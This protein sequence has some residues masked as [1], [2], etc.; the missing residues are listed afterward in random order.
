M[1]MFC[2]KRE[3][4]SLRFLLTP[5]AFEAYMQ[6]RMNGDGPFIM[7]ILKK[8]EDYLLLNHSFLFSEITFADITKNTMTT[9][10]KKLLVKHK[11]LF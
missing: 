8:Y 10:E 11:I 7:E 4:N 3:S 9:D 1:N 6:A 5:K 2:N